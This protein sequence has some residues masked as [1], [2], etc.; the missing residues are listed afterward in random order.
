MSDLYLV[1][2]AWAISSVNRYSA[3][4]TSLFSEFVTYL[5][6]DRAPAG[7]F[8][9][10]RLMVHKNGLKYMVLDFCSL[11]FFD[12]SRAVCC[13]SKAVDLSPKSNN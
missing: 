10:E 3:F 5:Q 8:S 6:P 4:V 1:R 13:H 11:P 12:I 2:G 7:Q 9:V